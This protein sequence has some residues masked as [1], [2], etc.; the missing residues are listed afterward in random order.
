MQYYLQIE[1]RFLTLPRTLVI[2]NSRVSFIKGK[3]QLKS[4]CPIEVPEILT[5]ANIVNKD[6]ET[7][8][9]SI[10]LFHESAPAK[11]IS[12]LESF[13]MLESSETD[14]LEMESTS[15]GSLSMSPQKEVDELND[16]PLV[17]S[18]V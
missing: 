18:L 7:L 1:S 10:D 6:E 3:G 13:E 9:D 2:C 14:S 12:G 11:T 8:F 4:R 5:L 16:A 15:E 17:K